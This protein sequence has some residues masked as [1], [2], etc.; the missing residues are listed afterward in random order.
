MIVSMYVPSMDT[1]MNASGCDSNMTFNLTF[2]YISYETI[3]WT[4][5]I[6][7]SMVSP[8]G[9]V[10]TA[11]GTYFD[12]IVN[13]S[14]CDSAMT[15]NIN[16]KYSVSRTDN[17]TLCPGKSHRVGPYLYTTAGTY[18]N[19]FSTI[20]GCDS[21]IIT[22]LSYYAPA[23]ATVNYN[24]CTGDSVM[25]VGNWYY[26][27][28]TFM[29]TIVGGSSNGCDSV[30]TH[31]LTTRTVS[32]ALNL[33]ADVVSCV[34][35]GVTVFAS[36]AYDTYNW[37]TGGTTNVLIVNGALS[38]VGTTNHILTVTQASSGC[39][40]TDDINVTFNS[41]V[42]L[43]EVDA[44]LNVNLY[45]NPANNFVT[46]EIFDKYNEGNLKLEILNSIGQV[47]SSRNI[48]SSNTKLPKL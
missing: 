29:D 41:C 18:T 40:A 27:A 33:G 35:G 36:T 44:D 15:F 34:D 38:G 6:C 20:P 45:P 4:G 11:S 43:N 17:I 39:T 12:T 25:I 28:T 19:V 8:S 5:V 21:T 42:G 24:F 22:N 10:W 1:I 47:V 14:G 37:S 13:A 48:S 3:T 9:K 32:P 16:I 2:G 7:D 46:I 26:A 31:N 23:V 30:T